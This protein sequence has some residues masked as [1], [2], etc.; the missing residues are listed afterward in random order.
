[1][2]S[3]NTSECNCK[4]TSFPYVNLQNTSC[5]S[6]QNVI[7]LLPKVILILLLYSESLSFYTKLHSINIIILQLNK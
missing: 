5:K 7:L 4:E 1:M 6:Y 2:K 3:C